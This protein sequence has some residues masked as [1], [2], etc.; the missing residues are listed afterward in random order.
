MFHGLRLFLKLME[1]DDTAKRRQQCLASWKSALSEPEKR[2][3]LDV[4][5]ETRF[6]GYSHRL[7]D[8]AKGQDSPSIRAW[9]I[10]ILA[11]LDVSEPFEQLVPLLGN[12]DYEL[13]RQLL[14]LFGS[15]KV[16]AAVPAIEKML[17]GPIVADATWQVDELKSMATQALDKISGKDPSAS[18]K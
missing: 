15:R 17:K 4:M 6:P 3:I 8:I 7:M 10:T 13:R 14:L 2:A 1:I 9:A 11:Y 16:K 5:W 12:S 18:W